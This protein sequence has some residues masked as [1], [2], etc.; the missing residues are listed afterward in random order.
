MATSAD[1]PQR[2]AWA[3]YSIPV[4]SDE[5][6]RIFDITGGATRPRRRLLSSS[7]ISHLMCLKA[8][9]HSKIVTMNSAL[10]NR[11]Q[12]GQKPKRSYNVFGAHKINP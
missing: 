8:W 10:F 4:M 5:P 7:K 11:L 9:L 3:L 12:A 1:W 2:T 6:E